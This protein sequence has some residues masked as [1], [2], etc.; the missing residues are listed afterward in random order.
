MNHTET[1]SAR[2]ELELDASDPLDLG[3][4]FFAGAVLPLAL[5]VH[6]RLEPDAQSGFWIGMLA[7]LSGVAAQLG[8]VGP[9]LAIHSQIA[10]NLAN[11]IGAPTTKQ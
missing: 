7:A 4:K 5:Q 8:G 3:E 10:E 11:M 2:G 1:I 9:S 6:Q